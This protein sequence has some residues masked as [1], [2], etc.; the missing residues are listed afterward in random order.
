MDIK[1]KTFDIRTWK[2]KHLFL[3]ISTT[4][5]DTLV[6]LLYQCVETRSREVFASVAVSTGRPHRT[7][8]RLSN[9]L[10]RNYRPTCELLYGTNT[11]NR[12][13]EPFIYKYHLH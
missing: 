9:V 4:G 2:K 5:I 3:D 6:P 12:K 10:E 1:R 7:S 13:L 8:S 11:S